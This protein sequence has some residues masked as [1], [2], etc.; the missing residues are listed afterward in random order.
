VDVQPGAPGL[1]SGAVVATPASGPAV[2][3]PLGF[4]KE[5]E[6]YDLTLTATGRDG[7]PA[8][9]ADAGVMN[10]DNG[11]LFAD[12]VLFDEDASVTL[13][14][15]PGNYH[16]LGFVVGADFE[17]VSLVGDPEVRVTGATSFSLD[18]RRAQPVA[19]GVEGV[20]T[21][22]SFADLGY[23]RLD[24]T[25]AFGLASSFSVGGELAEGGLFAEPTGGPV[26]VGRFEVEL[27]TRLLP[28][29]AGS[30]AT[31]PVL[32]DLLQYG[33]EVPDP[34][35][36]VLPAAE[37]ARLARV[38]S[39]YRNLNDRADYSDVRVGFAP[40]QFFASGSYEPIAVPRSRVEYLSPDPI[41]WLHDG[42]WSRGRRSSTSTARPS[43]PMSPAS[44]AR[45]GGSGRRCTP[46]GSATGAGTG[47]SSGWPTCGTPAATTASPGSSASRR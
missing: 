14:V 23:T 4:Y 32:Y 9:L 6:R 7:R 21:D 41:L 37:R 5:P 42:L 44:A 16:I 17:T 31:T 26:R 28:A 34:P 2:R 15:P 45:S 38:A 11:E 43:C 3:V 47:C 39:G 46:A 22:P 18:A 27:R 40:L 29:G 24:A 20:A 19:S 25:D 8:P 35:N 1:Y 12:F 33:G 30:S 10:V 36:W 13:R